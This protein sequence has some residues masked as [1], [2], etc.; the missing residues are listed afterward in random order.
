MAMR[1]RRR[2]KAARTTPRV[3]SRGMYA[4]TEIGT[5]AIAEGEGE[6]EG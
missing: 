5:V 6:E 4:A 2:G 3:R 1:Q